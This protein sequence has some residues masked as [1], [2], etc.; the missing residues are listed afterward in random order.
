MNKYECVLCNY[1]TNNQSN[2]LKHNKTTKHIKKEEE[3]TKIVQKLSE[4]SL[5]EDNKKY[6]N[7]CPYCGKSF[8]NASN[9]IRHKKIC[10]EKRELIKKVEDDK[11]PPER[12]P[13]LPRPRP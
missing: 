8:A 10:N 7:K 3:N 2:Y 9:I 13:W 1:S 12:P 11:K 5:F 4:N 6:Y